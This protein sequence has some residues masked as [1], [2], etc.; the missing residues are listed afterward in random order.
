MKIIRF[1][2]RVFV[3]AGHEDPKAP[4]VVKK[5]LAERGDLQVGRIQMVNWAKLAA[6]KRFARHY[7]E[8][9]QEVFIILDGP[10]RMQCGD[11]TCEL[12]A[13]DA[14]LV[15]PMEVHQM[16]SL[17]DRDVNYVVFGIS[18]NSGGQTVVCDNRVET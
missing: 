13:G 11:S 16:T 14:I 9:M 7:H 6:G 1:D 17:S 4:G 8:D 12:D 15:D 5:V 3:P 10:V 18:T 2:D